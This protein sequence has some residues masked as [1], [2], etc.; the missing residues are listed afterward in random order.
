M[1][2]IMEEIISPI[3]D[4]GIALVKAT[5]DQLLIAIKSLIAFGGDAQFSV[6]IANA[7]GGALPITGLIFDKVTIKAAVVAFNIERKTATQNVQETGTMYIGHDSADDI[8]RISDISGLDDSG[9]T[10]TITAAGQ[11]EYTSDDLTGASYVGTVRIG[12]VINIKQ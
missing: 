3:E 4:Q 2:D 10:F 12:Q 5:Q 9:V 7:Q 8:W 11:V 1:N 6:A